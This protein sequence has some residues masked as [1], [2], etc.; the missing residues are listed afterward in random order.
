MTNVEY[1]EIKWTTSRGRETFGYNICTLRAQDGTKY[2]CMGGGYDMLGTCFGEWL[3]AN[4]Q[5]RL[6]EIR[7]RA[8]NIV[9]IGN[10]STNHG[11]FY[12]MTWTEDDVRLDGA[13]G[14]ESIRRIAEAIGVHVK[15][16]SD[17]KGHTTGFIITTDEVAAS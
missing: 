9:S 17:A 1:L 15:S 6:W 8:Y 3:Q 13:C 11:G 14:L 16:T 7:E 5:D 12:G 10:R 4:Y 2:R